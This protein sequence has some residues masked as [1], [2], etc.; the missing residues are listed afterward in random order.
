MAAPAPANATLLFA[1]TNLYF[2]G[3]FKPDPFSVYQ[4][5]FLAVFC[6]GVG[7]IIGWLL[8]IF[9]GSDFKKAYQEVPRFRHV[10]VWAEKLLLFLSGTIT[11]SLD[12]YKFATLV[13]P[14]S[15][16]Q[17]MGYGLAGTAATFA[18]GL[19]WL[20]TSAKDVE[21]ETVGEVRKLLTTV[22]EQRDLALQVISIINAAITAKKNRLVALA[23]RPAVRTAQMTEA[24]GPRVQIIALIQILHGYFSR[25]RDVN[26]RMRVGIYMRNPEAPNYLTPLYSWDGEKED[27][28]S[29]RHPESMKVDAPGTARSL[30]VQCYR[31]EKPLLI[32]ED[33]A[34]A[35]KK[36]EFVFFS[37]S[38]R[39][40][41]QSMAAYRY[42]IK[43]EENAEAIVLAIDT[44]HLGLFCPQREFECD[45][46]MA[47]ICNR[48]E[49]ELHSLNL[50]S[51]LKT[52]NE[53]ATPQRRAV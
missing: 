53:P 44:S 38:Q 52:K 25:K 10:A 51:K 32:I 13:A 36:G 18:I 5:I 31:S 41:I 50:L 24:F 45:L 30:V 47:E 22:D 14:H 42:L 7:L 20:L 33:C 26:K 43:K 40:K 19:S 35:A 6:C 15:Y 12:L 17:L 29:K 16:A 4:N 37:E 3:P 49:L 9:V 2:E 34:A 21:K 39:G 23:Q 48:I 28:F 1:Q 46:V 11:A 27:C 8:S